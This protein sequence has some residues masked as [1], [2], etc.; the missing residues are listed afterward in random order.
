MTRSRVARAIFG[1][2]V[3]SLAGPIYA[4]AQTPAPAAP[5]PPPHEGTAEF[6]FV[7]TTGN[8]DTSAF[9]LGG[10]FIGRRAPWVFTT[11]AAFVQNDADGALRARSFRAAFRAARAITE[12]LSGFTEYGYLRD[13]FAGIEHRNVIDGGLSY[14][15]VRPDPHT[16]TIEGGL[17]YANEQ[18]LT[19]DDLSTATAFAGAGYKL[20]LS[21]NADISDDMRFG[22]SL[23]DADDWRYHN[24][25]AVNAKLVS[26]LSLKASNIVRFV[27]APVLG[28]DTTDTITSIAIVA[29]F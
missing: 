5:P 6:S 14:V 24:I 1:A 8:S 2:L 11:R 23:S 4:T 20:K 25:L 7:G 29:K 10:E 9:G 18:R 12:R 28:F 19:G 16:L 13:T 15:L 26:V 22:F 21:E 27:N 3:L 17:G